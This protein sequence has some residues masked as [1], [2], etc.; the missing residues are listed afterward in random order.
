MDSRCNVF[1]YALILFCKCNCLS[2][3]NLKTTK[4]NLLYFIPY[5]LMEKIF[6]CKLSDTDK[7][8]NIIVLLNIFK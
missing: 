7:K 4:Y 1:S 6:K 5:P 2:I 3:Q 8:H